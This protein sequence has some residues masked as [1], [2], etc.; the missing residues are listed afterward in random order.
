MSSHTEL[1]RREI[2]LRDE[3]AHRKHPSPLERLDT[4]NAPAA[5]AICELTYAH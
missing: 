4:G 2:R 3:R 5:F 1:I